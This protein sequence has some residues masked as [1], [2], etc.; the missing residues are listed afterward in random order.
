MPLLP[1]RIRR[2]FVPPIKC[3]GIK[4]RLV[5]F[6]ASNVAWDGGGT[7]VEPFL[8]SGVVLFNVAP[9]RAIAAD[10]NPHLI[11][12]YQAVQAGEVTAASVRE[13]L[14][15]EGARLLAEGEAHYYALRDRFN[16][17]HSPLDFL[18]LS[19]A[20]F[21]GVMRFNRAGG[22]N[23]PFC[24]KPERFRQAYVT[25]IANQV[26]DLTRLLVGRQWEFRVADWR[27]TMARATA[28][29]FVY[30]DPPYLGR[31]ADYYNRWSDADARALAEEVAVSPG[32][33]AL[34]MWKANRYRTNET[35][36]ELW[37]GHVERSVSHYYHVGATENLRNEME[38]AL[39][40]R[41]GFA[42][43]HQQ[44]VRPTARPQSSLFADL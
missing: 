2:V 21:N 42:A 40:I 16:E 3:Q 33:F 30:L 11:R 31:H 32:G 22:F 23:V 9:A 28:R 10:T 44:S 13:H 17:A 39:V 4:T 5:R 25:R 34:S 15:R 6:I 8:G 1:K 27:E 14:T 35:L 19:R 20:C 37:G 36:P 41:H 24:R 18:F 7:W 29:D 12:F 43:P 26:G 38:E